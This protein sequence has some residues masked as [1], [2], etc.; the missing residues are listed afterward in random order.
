MWQVT[1][2][3][4]ATAAALLHDV[5]SYTRISAE[6]LTEEFGCIIAKLV[7]ETSTVSCA[8]DGSRAYRNAMDR[9]HVAKASPTG[10]TIKVADLIDSAMTEL[11]RNPVKGQEALED[12]RTFLPVLPQADPTL[13]RAAHC[14][15][16]AY[17]VPMAA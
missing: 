12:L 6:A 3:E 13:L 16:E 1:L 10:Q 17:A 9:A 2:D 7:L 14:L 5:M 4:T 11:A 15:M 8:R